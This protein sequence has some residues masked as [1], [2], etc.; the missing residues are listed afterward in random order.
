MNWIKAVL[1]MS[2]STLIAC[3]GGSSESSGS[4]AFG[5]G[6]ASSSPTAAYTVSVD[7]QRAGAST[8]QISSTETVQAVATVT[9]SSGTPIEGVVVTF[10]QSSASLLTFA[11]SAATALTNAQGKANLD[12]GASNALKTGA[13]VVQAVAQIGSVS[14]TAA[15]SIQIA[16][17]T[18]AAL[19]KASIPASVNFVGAIPNGTA[20]VI[21]GAGGNG[22]SESAVLTFRVVDANNAPV[23]SAT[24]DFKLNVDNGGASISPQFATSNSDGL[25]NVTV[26][27]GT[28]PVS[29]VVTATARTDTTN[30]VRTLSDTVLVSNSVAVEGSFEIVAGRTNLIGN[31]TGDKTTIS[32]SVADKSGNPVADGVAVSFQTDFGV[33]G[34][35]TL[36]GCLTLNG[37]CSVEFQVQEPRGDGIA[38]VRASVRVGAGTT[39]TQQLKI[40]MATFSY[41]LVWPETSFPPVRSLKLTGCKQTFELKAADGFRRSVAA[42][43]SITVAY[44]PPGAAV[45]VRAGSPVADRRSQD[46]LPTDV[47]LEVDLTSASL[48]PAC[49]ADG[50]LFTDSGIFLLMKIQPSGFDS[51]N[52]QRITLDYPH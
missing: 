49:K 32:A 17:G 1:T 9:S 41:L 48:V 18:P 43:T 27:S 50:K 5:S 21:K 46:F 15:R 12:L 36:G 23:N 8:T 4:S 52:T 26:L 16:A 20:I 34:T 37:T 35:S 28:D 14:A 25:V 10:S 19:G 22:R 11:P 38:T 33:V 42:G 2:V 24:L 47:V 31:L 40:N 39:L 51:A 3:G 44:E 7:V 45:A 13:I 30:L 29:I 6:A